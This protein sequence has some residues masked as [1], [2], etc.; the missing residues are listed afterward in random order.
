MASS[1]WFS[2][3]TS[4]N[5]RSL[6]AMFYLSCHDGISQK[7]HD[8]SRSSGVNELSIDINFVTNLENVRLSNSV[9]NLIGVEK[10]G[11]D[12]TVGQSLELRARNEYCSGTHILSSCP[13]TALASYRWTSASIEFSTANRIEVVTHPANHSP[14]T[15]GSWSTSTVDNPVHSFRSIQISSGFYREQL[16]LILQSDADCPASFF[17]L[18]VNVNP[19]SKPYQRVGLYSPVKMIL[20]CSGE[21]CLLHG[22][23]VT[24]T[25]C[26]VARSDE[27][28]TAEQL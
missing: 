14:P 11:I 16:R 10:G 20:N 5:A 15:L 28:E 21:L 25:G 13:R 12:L 24:P 26:T 18:D 19:V 8:I 22:L 4:Y 1:F 23:P 27:H 17:G 2:L 9:H 7:L 6:F 3:A